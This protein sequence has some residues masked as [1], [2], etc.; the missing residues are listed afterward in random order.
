MAKIIGTIKSFGWFVFASKVNG[1]S[2][3]SRDLRIVVFFVLSFFYLRCIIVHLSTLYLLFCN[4]PLL[5]FVCLLA[6]AFSNNIIGFACLF[7]CLFLSLGIG[8]MAFDTRLGL[9]SDPPS[10]EAQKFIVAVQDFFELSQKLLLSIPSNRLRPYMDTP[11]LKKF[12]KV[13]DEILDIG[14][15]FVDKK[16]KELKETTSKGIESSGKGNA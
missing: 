14:K 11:T 16:V 6:F 15:V 13:A 5:V 10:P 12:F 1:N 9:Y 7:V 3:R 8:T 4:T 2:S